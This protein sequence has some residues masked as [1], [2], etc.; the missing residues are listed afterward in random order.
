MRLVKKEVVSTTDQTRRVRRDYDAARTPFQR[1]CATD[2]ISQEKR[3]ELE[4]LHDQTN[5]R[6]LRQQI[7]DLIDHLFSLAGAEPGVTENVL[8]TLAVP[9]P[10]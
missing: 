2:A 6:Q 5:P 3:E 7:H 1:L 4:Q 9:I 8:D 10:V